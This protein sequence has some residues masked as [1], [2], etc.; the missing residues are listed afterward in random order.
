MHWC[1]RAAMLGVK[2]IALYALVIC[3][4]R[5][6]GTFL[7]T[8]FTR[9]PID[10][11]ARAPWDYD[12]ICIR[13]IHIKRGFCFLI[14]FLSTKYECH[15]W[16]C[17]PCFAT[18]YLTYLPASL[19]SWYFRCWGAWS[20]GPGHVVGPSRLSRHRRPADRHCRSHS[21]SQ[22]RLAC[23]AWIKGNMEYLLHDY[24]LTWIA[25]ILGVKKNFCY[26]SSLITF[27]YIHES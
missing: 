23:D 21:S 24:I 7:T 27:Y 5:A 4:Q 8:A 1:H 25:Y 15:K 11:Q 22:I 13:S 3:D 19:S 17:W 16:M 10:P 12:V 6:T 2:A 20:A 18:K 9:N 14:T 26:F